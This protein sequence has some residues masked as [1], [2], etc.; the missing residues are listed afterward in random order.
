MTRSLLIPRNIGKGLCDVW[1]RSL[2]GRKSGGL[3]LG[4][5]KVFVGEKQIFVRRE[6][7]IQE[8]RK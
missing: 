4:V 5:Y 7:I 1:D 8:H 6:P 3:S 2:G